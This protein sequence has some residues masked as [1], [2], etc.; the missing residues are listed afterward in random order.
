MPKSPEQFDFSKQEGQQKFEK[1]PKKKRG[2]FI[3]E[4]MTEATKINKELSKKES[5]EIEKKPF[6]FVY[7][8]NDLFKRYIPLIQNF[9]KEQGYPVNLQSFPAGT[10]EEEIKDWHLA[11]QTELQSGNVLA[12]NTVKK[13]TRYELKS[14]I[15]LD[16]LMNQVTVEAITG[17]ATS[18]GKSLGR[19]EVIRDPKNLKSLVSEIMENPK[20]L[21]KKQEYLSTLG[22]MYKKILTSIPEEKRQKLEVVILRGLFEGNYAFPSLIAH[23]PYYPEVKNFEEL[24]KETNEFADKMR[25]WFE[26]AG[27]SNINIFSTGAEIPTKTIRKLTKGS[28]YIIFDRHT[29]TPETDLTSERVEKMRKFWGNNL[30]YS[31]T[32]KEKSALQTP[33][34]TFYSDIQKKIGINADPQKMEELIKTRLQEELA[35]I[36]ETKNI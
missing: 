16:S 2:E 27:I 23:E 19:G 15:N 6:F 36:K 20:N 26:G 28:A 9:L 5:K 25:E 35:E 14:K 31:Q 32:I 13:S 24:R 30:M 17:D 3:E 29:Y 10:S 8:E 18:F 1:L 22:E 34:E 4:S 11:H 12:D 7:R 21:E 33:I